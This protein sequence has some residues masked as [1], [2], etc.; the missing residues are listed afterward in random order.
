MGG[1]ALENKTQATTSR[2]SNDFAFATEETLA[3]LAFSS[4]T[5]KLVALATIFGVGLF[6]EEAVEVGLGEGED[7][8]GCGVA[9]G[10]D[11]GCDGGELVDW[12]VV[13]FDEQ[14]REGDDGGS[15]GVEALAQ[16]EVDAAAA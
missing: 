13:G 10:G 15:L 12:G 2:H 1:R 16:R 7:G 6:E 5:Y 9:G 8:V 14:L 4:V 3:A 11:G